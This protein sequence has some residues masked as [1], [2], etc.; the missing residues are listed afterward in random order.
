[1]ERPARRVVTDYSTV[2]G[3]VQAVGLMR[4]RYGFYVTK[5]SLLLLA[6]AGVWVGFAFLGTH[7]AQV[8]IAVAL[9]I[10]VT[11]ILFMSHD[12]AHRQIFRSGKAN[13]WAALLLGTGL[14]GVSLGWWHSKHT[15]HH[16][17]PNQ[18]GKDPDINSSVLRFYATDD[19]PRHRATAFLYARQGWWFYPLL[20]AEALNL[21]AQ[22]IMTVATRRDVKHRWVEAALLT[23]RLGVYPAVLFIVLPWGLAAAFL[24]VQLAATGL[25]LGSAFAVSHVG[26]PTVAKDS[27]IDFF[28]RQ[29][30]TSRNVSGGRAA[31]LAMGGLNYQIEHHLFPGMPRPNLRRAR[32]IVRAFCAEHGIDY[33]EVPIHH[34][35]AIVAAHLNRVGLS[36]ALT[37]S[38]P[39]AAALR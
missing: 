3:Q 18:I 6:F 37:A 35:W 24:G 10:V 16:Q 19:A 1:M 13:E 20:V 5:I 12:A 38:C 31:S 36:A 15:R 8:T 23:V 17:A 25:Y 30:L 34:A 22:S 28:R 11:Q 26:M 7:W 39:T 9:A 29:V 4:R 2:L 33:H 27:K 32:P 14:G 21:H